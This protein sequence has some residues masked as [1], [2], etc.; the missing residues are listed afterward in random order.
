M[1]GSATRQEPIVLEYR[2]TPEMLQDAIVE[3]SRHLSRRTR[4]VLYYATMLALGATVGIGATLA[5]RHLVP[6]T[7]SGVL[8]ATFFAGFL[9]CVFLWQFTHRRQVRQLSRDS[10][11]DGETTRATL[12][13]DG[14]RFVSD[15][16]EA[17]LS[18]AAISDVWEQKN[19]MTLRTRTTSF[20]IPFA[21]FPAGETREGL[22]AAVTGWRAVA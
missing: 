12:S 11:Q 21:A 20:P 2:L 1:S 4:G 9:T 7:D 6:D 14:V 19:A 15:T 22:I 8:I 5:E 16:A 10:D 3:A 17:F 13:A 18:W